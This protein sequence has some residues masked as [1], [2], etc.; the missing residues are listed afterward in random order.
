MIA[1]AFLDSCKQTVRCHKV[2]ELR[3]D[4]DSTPVM[5]VWKST[6]HKNIKQKNKACV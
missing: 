2:L 3:K 4:V 6:L 5:M 1:N